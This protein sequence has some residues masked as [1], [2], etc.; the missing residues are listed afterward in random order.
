MKNAECVGKQQK[1]FRTSLPAVERWQRFEDPVLR[2]DKIARPNLC[3]GPWCSKAQQKPMYENERAIAYCDI[4]LYA[5]STVV[6]ANRIDATTVDKESETVAV[7]EMSCPWIQQNRE[8]KTDETTAKYGP[9]RW[10]L[11][12]RFPKYKMTHYNVIIE[13]L[14]D[15][16]KM[17]AR[18]LR[19]WLE[20][21]AMY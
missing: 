15:I 7:L 13:V 1:V 12:Q 8:G 21:R 2:G 3:S 11:K 16:L 6:K 18:H 4:P 10:E 19:S 5:D 20:R 17:S 9:L 14:G